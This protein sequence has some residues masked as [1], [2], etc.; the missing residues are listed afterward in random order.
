MILKSNYGYNL[1]EG[2]VSGPLV[3]K[4]DS[5]GEKTDPMLGFFVSGNFSNVIDPRPLS[6]DQYRLNPSMRD[7]LIDPS[8]LGPLRPTG[9]G[10]GAYYN[11]DFLTPDAFEKVKFRQNVANTNA[12]L[13]GKI[14]VNAGPNMNL[15]FGASGAYAQRTGASWESSIFNFDNYGKFTDIDWRAYGKFTQRFQQVFEENI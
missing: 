13:A 1:I 5:T 14:D 10:F 4:K 6:S 8:L 11:T 15:T 7:S 3:M 9:L 2:V 12:S